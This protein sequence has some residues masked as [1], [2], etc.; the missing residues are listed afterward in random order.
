MSSLVVE[1]KEASVNIISVTWGMMATCG[2]PFL[3][4]SEVKITGFR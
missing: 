1:V 2:K 4:H 3:D